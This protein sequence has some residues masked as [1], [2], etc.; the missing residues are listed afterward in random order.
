MTEED[1]DSSMKLRPFGTEEARQ[2]EAQQRRC[3]TLG[4]ALWGK[5]PADLQRQLLAP[6]PEIPSGFNMDDFRKL[7][8]IAR[9][10]SV[11]SGNPRFAWLPRSVLSSPVF[12][13]TKSFTTWEA[14]YE[15]V[16]RAIEHLS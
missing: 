5:T 12:V 7:L 8:Q 2:A 15:I 1:F 3:M 11:A 13:G 14:R 9:P 16:R 10:L 6:H 4:I